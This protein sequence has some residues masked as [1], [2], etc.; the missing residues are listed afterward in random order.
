MARSA[1]EKGN[2]RESL[3]LALPAMADVKQSPDGLYLLATDY[4]NT[5]NRS[6]VADLPKDWMQLTGVP[7]D[8]SIKFAVLLA[9]IRDNV[10]PAFLAKVNI[11]VRR[12]TAV[13]IEK[14]LEQKI[15]FQRID[16]AE[17]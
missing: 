5:G 3:A 4:V 7:E 12:L 9:N 15:V 16:V 2:Y 11:D 1:S 6:A 17:L 13:S 8:W 14:P 10:V